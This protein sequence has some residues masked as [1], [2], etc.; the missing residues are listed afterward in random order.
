MTE[1]RAQRISWH[2]GKARGR[3]APKRPLPRPTEF[4]RG[5]AGR[6]ATG[7]WGRGHPSR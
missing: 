3:G 2:A 5:H 4:Q 6:P 1:P 7:G